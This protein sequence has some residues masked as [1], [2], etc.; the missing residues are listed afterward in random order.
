MKHT[1]TNSSGFT[2]IELLVVIAIIA[3]LAGMLLPA[4]AKA[5]TKAASASCM[6]NLNQLQ[7]AWIMYGTDNDD[8]IPP[9]RIVLKGGQFTADAGSWVVGNAWIDTT[10]SNV[11]A[12]VLYPNLGSVQAFRCPSDRSKVRGNSGL[13]RTRS[14]AASMHLNAYAGP[15]TIP[16][17]NLEDPMPR[18]QSMLPTPGPARIYVF[19]DE[20]ENSIDDGA[21]CFANPYSKVGS[22]YPPFWDDYPADRHGNG[23]NVSFADGHVEHWRWKARRK[24]P[25][26]SGRVETAAPANAA[27]LS[28][29]KRFYNSVPGAP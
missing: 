20:H 1:N 12:G 13:L 2:L 25:N 28:D 11:M 27:D 8:W 10:P 6:N 5:K 16:E 9:N 4:L 24:V 7:K 3:I 29:L 19:T 21:F 23:S 15:G 18:K 17:I 22:K 14:Y 26:V